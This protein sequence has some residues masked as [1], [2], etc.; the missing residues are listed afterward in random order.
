MGENYLQIYRNLAEDAVQ[1]STAVLTEKYGEMPIEL[2]QLIDDA[3][4]TFSVFITR[5]EDENRGVF[6]CSYDGENENVKHQIDDI[7]WYL[8]IEYHKFCDWLN[9]TP[10]EFLGKIGEL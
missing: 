9:K 2:Q 4:N 5:M 3:L 1:N 8:N 6:S 7:N 10:N